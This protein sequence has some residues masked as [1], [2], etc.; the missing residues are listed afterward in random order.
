MYVNPDINDLYN[1]VKAML[2]HNLYSFKT[3]FVLSITKVPPLPTYRAKSHYLFGVY[4][5]LNGV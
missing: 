1:C 3:L 2:T 5:L 4:I